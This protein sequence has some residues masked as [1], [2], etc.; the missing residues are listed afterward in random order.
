M[1]KEVITIVWLLLPAY[2]ANGSPVII[3]KIILKLRL[4][5]HPMDFGKNFIDG[6]R[7]FGDSKSW[8]GFVGGVLTGTLTGFIQSIYMHEMLAKGAL[9]GFVL[10]V[11]AMLGDLLGAFIK[12]RLGLKPGDPLPVLDQLLFIVVALV[13]ASKLNLIILSIEEWVYAIV[14]TFLL[15]ILT[16]L[17]AYLLNLKSVPW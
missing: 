2:F 3:S 10:G 11:G 4:K 16:N 6:K 7:V 8:E 1:L 15:H 13:L 12:R 5:K 14:V 17:I 9:T